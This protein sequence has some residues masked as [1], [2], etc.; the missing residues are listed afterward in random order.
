MPHADS[1]A[2]RLPGV[3]RH[4][5][6]WT[7]GALAIAALAL[8]PVATVVYMA[9]GPG[10]SVW[11]RLAATALPRYFGNTLA[12]VASVGLLSALVGVLTAWLVA[13]Y[14]FPFSRLTEAALML[15]MACP[16]YVAAYSLV[17]FL[18]YAGPLQRGLRAL[19]G[20]E[21]AADYFFPEIRSLPGA[22]LVLAATLYPYVYLFA[23][24]AFLEQP[25]SALDVARVLGSGPLRRL[26]RVSIPMARPSIFA[27]CAI[28]MM[29]TVNDLGVVEHFSVQTLTTGI[30]SVWLEGGNAAAASQI[31]CAALVLVLA[32]ALG[33]RLALRRRRFSQSVRS[34]APRVRAEL[35]GPA[36][37]LALAACWIPIL[38]G[39]VIPV[40]TL[41][42]VAELRLESWI[43][44]PLLSA[45]IS[46]ASV[47]AAAALVTTALAI[48]MV[49][50]IRSGKFRGL[51]L[52]I[53]ATMVGYAIPGAVLGVGLLIPLAGLDHFL[54]DA[55]EP[56]WGEWSGMLLTG[57]VGA[58][59]IGYFTRFFA[60]AQGKAD[61][62]MG[63]LPPSISMA[64]RSLGRTPFGTLWGVLRPLMAHSV[65]TAMLL[66]FIDC[67]KELP[68]TLL[69]RP[70]GFHT[71]ATR[72]YESASL[73]NLEG[74]A[75]AALLLTF[76][77]G[78]AVALLLRAGGSSR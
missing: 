13:H 8:L 70:F 78:V 52:L 30:F 35:R 16:G 12:L 49:Y 76:F 77:G 44:W 64:S 28:V 25:R 60:L 6:P 75:P 68:A 43:S 58:L 1:I 19:F 10:E 4:V 45:L 32:L 73:E 65:V 18:E 47:S 61:S 46:S 50:G 66:V 20:W 24:S 37:W 33:E 23:R 59:L 17:D 3:L 71:L 2:G 42:Y 56:V 53:P 36:R 41:L 63:R 40:G 31:A 11:P 14:R 55:L 27:G 29:E 21:S 26:A 22:A 62:S 7:A 15:P 72:V 51:E 5:N 39:F 48:V 38:A 57:S 34:Q 9:F 54:A 74:A 69:L 67:M